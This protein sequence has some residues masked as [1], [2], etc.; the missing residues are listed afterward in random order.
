MIKYKTLVTTETTI[1]SEQ[2]VR[3][4]NEELDSVLGGKNRYIEEGIIKE[5]IHT[6]TIDGKLTKATEKEIKLYEAFKLVEQHF[7]KI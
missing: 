2:I 7:N 4:L 5:R 6:F 3:I 1:D